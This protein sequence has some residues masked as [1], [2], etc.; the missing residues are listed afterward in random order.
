MKYICE[1]AKEKL[2]LEPEDYPGVEWSTILKIFSMEEAERIVIS[3]YKFEAYGK[4]R[5]TTTPDT[6]VMTPEEFKEKIL[7]IKEEYYDGIDDEE[8]WH[9][10]ADKIMCELL[11]NLGYGEGIDIFNQTPKWYS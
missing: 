6:R 5:T 9:R 10:R 11:R 1:Q 2:I 3:D 4:P 8:V 7:A